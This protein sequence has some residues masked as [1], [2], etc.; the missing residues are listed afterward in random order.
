MRLRIL[1]MLMLVIILSSC[2]QSLQKPS[3]L[4]FSSTDHKEHETAL[5]MKQTVKTEDRIKTQSNSPTK[6]TQQKKQKKTTNFEHGIGTVTMVIKISDN[7]I[8]LAE[9]NVT[10]YKNDTALDALLR[11]TKEK[12]IQRDISGKGA[13]AYIRGIANVYEMDDGPGS[14]WMFRINGEFVNQS[15]GAIKLS[16]GDHIEWLYTKDLGQDL[17]AP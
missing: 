16:S 1:I 6:P 3:G 2:G 5:H 15:A 8:P 13:S 11:I 17:D 9:T 10:I 14:G 7:N 4:D 12:N